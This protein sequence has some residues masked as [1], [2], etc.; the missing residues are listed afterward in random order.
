MIVMMKLVG[1]DGA[2]NQSKKWLDYPAFLQY[3][4]TLRFLFHSE[5]SHL[6]LGWIGN[7]GWW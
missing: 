3:D 7:G 6:E 4:V 1:D 2:D 5:S